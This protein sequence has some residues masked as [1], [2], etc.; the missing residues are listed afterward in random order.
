LKAEEYSLSERLMR[1]SYYPHYARI[2][3]RYF[4]DKML[5]VDELKKG[6]KTQ[7]TFT[8][9]S[10]APLPDSVFTKAYLEKVNR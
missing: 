1:T 6:E 7:L 4:P 8:D 5:F 9:L 10:I 3:D 2:E